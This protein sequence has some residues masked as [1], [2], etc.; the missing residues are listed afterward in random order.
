MLSGFLSK[1][2]ASRLKIPNNLYQ[3]IIEIW[4]ELS[5]QN[6]IH[7]NYLSDIKLHPIWNN[8][9]I[10]NNNQP[11]FY[12]TWSEKGVN[13][14][15]DILNSVNSVYRFMSLD[16]FTEKYALQTDFVTF[17]GIISAIRS[18]YKN[19]K[20]R[21]ELEQDSG[22]FLEEFCNSTKAS[23]F[24]YSKLIKKTGKEAKE[25]GIKN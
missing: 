6:L 4:T 1:E 3:E 2:D 9:G 25:N 13:Y 18:Y 5:C 8:S 20:A 14:I 22:T 19:C 23:K 21:K 7:A 11:I 16:T 10:R 12:K 17:S 24:S 15:E